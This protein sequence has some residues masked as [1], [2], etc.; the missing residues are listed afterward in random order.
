MG[1]LFETKNVILTT[2]AATV[3]ATVPAYSAEAGCRGFTIGLLDLVT[4]GLGG[5]VS[6]EARGVTNYRN[7]NGTF[8]DGTTASSS[9]AIP[10]SKLIRFNIAGCDGFRI[11][12]VTLSAASVTAEITMMSGGTA[13]TT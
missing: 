8:L 12:V 13:L 7:I 2:S 11:N 5:S 9:V 1:L 4:S 10:S 3:S 6:F